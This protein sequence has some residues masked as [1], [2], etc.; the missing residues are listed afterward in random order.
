M[1]ILWR[2]KEDSVFI[3]YAK[4]YFTLSCR[5][6][7]HRTLWGSWATYLKDVRKVKLGLELGLWLRTWNKNC[8]IA[9]EYKAAT[10]RYREETRNSGQ[11]SSAVGGGCMEVAV[12]LT[13]RLLI[14]PLVMILMCWG[15]PVSSQDD[16][17]NGN[18][19]QVDCPPG[20][21]SLSCQAGAALPTAFTQCVFSIY[22]VNMTLDIY[23]RCEWLRIWYWFKKERW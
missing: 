1:F 15:S 4:P 5:E 11:M 6:N 13:F 3:N 17:G 23:R 8:V 7:N 2:A 10:A 9:A 14:T 19:T 12:P 18:M 22:S 20:H 16:N 21:C